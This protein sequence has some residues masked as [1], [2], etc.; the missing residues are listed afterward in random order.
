MGR[1]DTRY[2]S[3]DRSGLEVLKDLKKLRPRL[4]VLILSMH[5]EEQYARRAFKAGAAGY[6]PKIARARNCWAQS[7]RLRAAASM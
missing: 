3:Q 5:S 2:F 7:R 6:S 4:P 1:C